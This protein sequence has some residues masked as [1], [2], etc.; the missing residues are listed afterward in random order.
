MLHP[1]ASYLLGDKIFVVEGPRVWERRYITHTS[2]RVCVAT[3]A[4]T[5]EFRDAQDCYPYDQRQQA[6]NAALD[7]S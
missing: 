6:F 3:D 1:N 7:I 5:V 2:Y 4:G